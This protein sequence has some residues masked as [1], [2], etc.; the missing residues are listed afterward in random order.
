[1]I[2]PNWH[3]MMEAIREATTV[4]DVIKIHDGFLDKC[5]QECL[6]TSHGEVKV[7][8]RRQAECL[9]CQWRVQRQPSRLQSLYIRLHW[10]RCVHPCRP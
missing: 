5:L 1:M 3:N 2:Q 7:C 8:V 4:D 9:L 10:T 6:L